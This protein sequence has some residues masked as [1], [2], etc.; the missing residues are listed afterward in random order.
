MKVT[1]EL[2]SIELRISREDMEAARMDPLDW[3]RRMHERTVMR[4]LGIFPDGPTEP[5][6]EPTE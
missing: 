1:Y 2:R 3:Y 5:T 6:T 4:K